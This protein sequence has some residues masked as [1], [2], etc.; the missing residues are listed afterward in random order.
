MGGASIR[1]GPGTFGSISGGT[2]CITS[3]NGASFSSASSTAGSRCGTLS[4]TAPSSGGSSKW[5]KI[6]AVSLQHM[7]RRLEVTL[8]ITQV[9]TNGNGFRKPAAPT[10]DVNDLQISSGE[11]SD[12]D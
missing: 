11:S 8:T 12:S 7:E 5:A 4:S 6:P 10:I 3:T 1:D 2:S 9:K